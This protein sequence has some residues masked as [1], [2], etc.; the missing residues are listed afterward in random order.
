MQP[1][2]QSSS[3]TCNKMSPSPVKYLLI[4]TASSLLEGASLP[5]IPQVLAY[6]STC[7]I[8][9]PVSRAWV[10]CAWQSVCAAVEGSVCSRGPWGD[11]GT[12]LTVFHH[13]QLKISAKFIV[14]WHSCSEC[15][16]LPC[17][18]FSVFPAALK[19]TGFSGFLRSG[20]HTLCHGKEPVREHRVQ[21]LLKRNPHLSGTVVAWSHHPVLLAHSQQLV[22][23][24]WSVVLIHLN[25]LPHLLMEMQSVSNSLKISGI[26]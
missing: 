24:S 20:M 9:N 4:I 17:A 22:L 2:A 12:V 5:V 10:F 11:A 21:M 18:L 7:L 26:L 25:L 16:P 8:L 23:L 19:R 13:L 1:G 14:W 3:H 6:L 15:S